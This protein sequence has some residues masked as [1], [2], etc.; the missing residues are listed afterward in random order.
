METEGRKLLEVINEHGE[1]P[2]KELLQYVPRKSDDYRDFY[3]AANLMHAGYFDYNAGSE[4]HSNPL[5]ESSRET[6]MIFAQIMLPKGKSFTVNGCPRE[7]WHNF[8][9]VAFST[10]KGFLKLEEISE[11]ERKEARE[12]ST[13]RKDYFMSLLTGIVVALFASWVFHYYALERAKEVGALNKSFNDHPSGWTSKSF[14]F[15]GPLTKRYKP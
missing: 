10:A 3:L 5:G 9:V 2:A 8:P 6:A 14:A 4:R 12:R 1:I 13:K 7:S 15:S 11:T